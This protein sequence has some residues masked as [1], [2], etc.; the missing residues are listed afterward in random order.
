MSESATAWPGQEVLQWPGQEV[1]AGQ[2]EHGYAAAPPE[3]TLP[4]PWAGPVQYGDVAVDSWPL[5]GEE[6]PRPPRPAPVDPSAPPPGDTQLTT[7]QLAEEQAREASADKSGYFAL[8]PSE[9]GFG[10]LLWS[11]GAPFAR[12]GQVPW[13]ERPFPAGV[14]ALETAAPLAGVGD[15]RFAPR[16]SPMMKSYEDQ[17]AALRAARETAEQYGPPPPPPERFG[18]PMAPDPVVESGV[19]RVRGQLGV[20]PEPPPP[21]PVPAEAVPPGVPPGTEVPTDLRLRAAIDAAGSP[22][23][24]FVPQTNVDPLSGQVTPVRVPPGAAGPETVPYARPAEVPPVAAPP[25]MEP[26]GPGMGPRSAWRGW[27]A[28]R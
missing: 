23:P 24:G 21:S 9:P 27:H 6:P 12:I 5:P 26:P 16:V 22:R 14:D 1:K 15:L 13:H 17:S 19:A 11:L 4:G 20:G 28:I 25:P 7:A 2:G 8:E 10:H 3:P 18:P